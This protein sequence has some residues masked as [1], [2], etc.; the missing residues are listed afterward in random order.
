[1]Q[2]GFTLFL[3]RDNDQRNEYVD[4][5]EWKHDEV[6]DVE[7][8]PLDVV[9]RYGAFV[10][11]RGG[12]RVLQHPA[13]GNGKNVGSDEHEERIGGGEGNQRINVYSL[14][15]TLA[16]LHGKQRQHRYSHVVVV[17]VLLVPFPL[18]RGRH[19]LL[20]VHVFRF[21][22]FVLEIVTPAKR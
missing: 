12:Y 19:E 2:F 9:V 13:W 21:A 8:R 16:G 6:N 7:Q 11:F 15:P 10:Q 4:E 20:R 17:K 14:R 1:M 5:E 3:K 22:G 18:F